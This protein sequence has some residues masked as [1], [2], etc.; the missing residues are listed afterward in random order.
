MRIKTTKQISFL[1]FSNF[2][3]GF[4][5]E[6]EAATSSG[7][8]V[9]WKGGIARNVGLFLA[10][11]PH[12]VR[13]KDLDV[14][15]GEGSRLLEVFQGHD[16]RIFERG[17]DGKGRVFWDDLLD[18][19]NTLNNCMVVQLGERVLW[20]AGEEWDCRVCRVLEVYGLSEYEEIKR[21]WRALIFSYRYRNMGVR[22]QKGRLYGWDWDKGGY[23]EKQLVEINWVFKAGRAKVGKEN[24]QDFMGW[25][26]KV[27]G[28]E[29]FQGLMDKYWD[30]ANYWYPKEGY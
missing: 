24:W 11:R 16:H 29:V 14:N 19:D 3:G 21:E 26:N 2:F 8:L 23:E 4:E 20:V 30:E 25:V 13:Q 12:V 9:V 17:N 1:S 10:G 15:L 27:R 5:G 18:D 22:Y 28:E 7:E 6:L